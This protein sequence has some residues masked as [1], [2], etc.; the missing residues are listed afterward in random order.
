MR[1]ETVTDDSMGT[2][3][4]VRHLNTTAAVVTA[5]LMRDVADPVYAVARAMS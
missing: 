3:L 4:G 5:E 1:T 2:F